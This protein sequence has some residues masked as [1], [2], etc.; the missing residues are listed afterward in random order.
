MRSNFSILVIFIGLSPALFAQAQG[1]GSDT[2]P[3]HAQSPEPQ[4]VPPGVILV[5]GAWSS[6]SDSL[7][8]LPEGGSIADKAIYGEPVILAFLIRCPSFDWSEKYNRARL[9]LQTQVITSWPVSGPRKSFEGPSRGSV[10]IAAQ[11][12]FFSLTPGDN[13]IESIKH[14]KE[15]LAADYTVER[16]PT[17]VRIANHTFA[18][19]DYMSPVAGLHWYVLAT[20]IRV[21]TW[22]N[23]VFT[24]RDTQLLE[25]LIPR[26]EQ[27]E[28]AGG[29]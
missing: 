19:F 13:A 3:P 23:S 11:D 8:P 12:M 20:E 10:M 27:A 15:T 6:A 22:F 5:K 4:K 24:S 14:A 16:Q 26:Y 25:T 9:L 28:D 2:L 7:T 18:R 21:A 17:E 1:P 29:G